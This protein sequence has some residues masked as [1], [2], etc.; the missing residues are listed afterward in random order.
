M[1]EHL[2]ADLGRV[3]RAREVCHLVGLSR[4]TL[5]RLVRRNEF[6]K[7]FSLSSSA[8]VGWAEREVND[9]IAER[10][11]RRPSESRAQ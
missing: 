10:A 1:N 6:P 2:A 4:P 9:W 3:L 8:A 7:P 5:W 11:A